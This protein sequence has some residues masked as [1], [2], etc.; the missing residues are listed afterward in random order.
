M[1]NS[2]LINSEIFAH[3]L[4]YKEA[5]SKNFIFIFISVLVQKLYIALSLAVSVL[6]FVF[7]GLTFSPFLTPLSLDF[8]QYFLSQ[9][10]LR[11]FSNSFLLW[12]QITS[13][14]QYSTVYITFELKKEHSF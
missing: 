4:I 11:N 1:T 9:R 13:V 7:S 8:A 14:I 2:L 6:L 10:T 5:L 12:S 3:F